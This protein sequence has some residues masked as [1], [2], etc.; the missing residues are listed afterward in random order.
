MSVIVGLSKIDFV[1]VI[2]RHGL[3]QCSKLLFFLVSLGRSIITASIAPFSQ[4]LHEYGKVRHVDVL[5]GINHGVQRINGLVHSCQFVESVRETQVRRFILFLTS[6]STWRGEG[7]WMQTYPS[8]PCA[9]TAVGGFELPADW[10]DSAGA[11]AAAACF[12]CGSASIGGF[13]FT[14]DLWLVTQVEIGG[15]CGWRVL[16]ILFCERSH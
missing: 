1:A 5:F 10:L 7:V 12:G 11:A 8:R 14:C 9:A 6:L 13:Y 4:C 2:P 16:T 15:N 3:Y